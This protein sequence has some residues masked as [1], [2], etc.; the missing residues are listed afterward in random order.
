MNKKLPYFSYC[1][2]YN[3]K[4]IWKQCTNVIQFR[5]GDNIKLAPAINEHTARVAVRWV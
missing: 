2:I 3:T 1:F 5:P 4:I